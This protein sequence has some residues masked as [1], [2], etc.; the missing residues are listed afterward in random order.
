LKKRIWVLT[1]FPEYFDAF[2]KCGV[3]GKALA[4]ERMIHEKN[5]FELNIVNIRDYALNKYKSVD[6]T[7][8][9]GGAGMVMLPE[10]L[11]NAFMKGIVEAGQYRENFKDQLH[12]IYTSPRGKTWDSDY[13]KNISSRFFQFEP[14]EKDLV[15]I[16]GRYEGIDERFLANYV[17]EHISLGDFILTG[18]ELAVLVFLDSS[19]RYVPGVLGNKVSAEEE[20]FENNL[21]EQP[22]YT[23]PREFEGIQV[24]EIMLSGHH[25]KIKKFEF[26]EKMR[27]TKLYRPDLYE[28]YEQKKGKK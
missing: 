2:L 10:V 3:A 6:D 18:G 28:K 7:A 9:G 22:Q 17:D 4:N 19:L 27:M 13:A 14:N 24:P 23:K 15:F 25:E 12:V 21:L 26:E 16:C 5:Q 1:L 11:K 8:Y 20:S